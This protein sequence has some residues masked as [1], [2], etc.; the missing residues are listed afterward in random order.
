MFPTQFKIYHFNDGD[1]FIQTVTIWHV[2]Y[3]DL[4]LLSPYVIAILLIIFNLCRIFA[5]RNL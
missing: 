2:S 1:P 4:A 5:L 3:L